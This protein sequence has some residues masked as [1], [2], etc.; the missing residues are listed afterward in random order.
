LRQ[1]EEIIEFLMKKFSLK[2]ESDLA[3]L[4]GVEANTLSGWKKREKIPFENLLNLV[5]DKK[6]SFDDILGI[7]H[8]KLTMSDIEKELLFDFR[9]L[10]K[11]K[12]NI[13][14]LRIKADAI[15][16]DYSTS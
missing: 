1:I 15:E 5:K 12:Q 9:R 14:S 11:E 8:D 10:A 16:G 6:M 7:N 3:K 13:Y 2:T 4:L